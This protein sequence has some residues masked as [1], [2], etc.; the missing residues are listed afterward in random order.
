MTSTGARAASQGCRRGVDPGGPAGSPPVEQAGRQKVCKPGHGA[1]GTKPSRPQ[2]CPAARQPDL[3]AGMSW[4]AEMRPNR[5][6][7]A[8]KVVTYRI[9]L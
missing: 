7:V 5:E 2:P 9:W 3:I 4:P 1:A 8:E 6:K